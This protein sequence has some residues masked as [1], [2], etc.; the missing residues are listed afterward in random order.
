MNDL[1]SW[2]NIGGK[3]GGGGGGGIGIDSLNGGCCCG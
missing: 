2:P 3:P 1:G